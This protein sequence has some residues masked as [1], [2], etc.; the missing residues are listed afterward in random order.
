MEDARMLFNILSGVER[1]EYNKLCREG[2]SGTE[3]LDGGE[4][5]GEI[6]VVSLRSAIGC[7][8]DGFD[9][10][11]LYSLKLFEHQDFH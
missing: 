7:C 10:P 2:R 6:C 5:L 9:N 11:S 4:V 3:N 1:L 8:L